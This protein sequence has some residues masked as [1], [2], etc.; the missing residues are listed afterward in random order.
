MADKKGKGKLKRELSGKKGMEAGNSRANVKDKN[1]AKEVLV[2][3]DQGL[4]IHAT[5]DSYEG[6]FEARKKDR[7]VKMHGEC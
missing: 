7:S 4:F 5:G 3:Q 6:F 2:I 1:A